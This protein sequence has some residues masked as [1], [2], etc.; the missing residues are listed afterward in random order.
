MLLPAST[1]SQRLAPSYLQALEPIR[2]L[3]HLRTR[4][5]RLMPLSPLFSSA[6][7]KGPFTNL[8]TSHQQVWYCPGS[9]QDNYVK[10]VIVKSGSDLGLQFYQEQNGGPVLVGAVYPK[11]QV[12]LGRALNFRPSFIDMIPRRRPLPQL[13]AL[14][15]T[16]LSRLC[17]LHS[18]AQPTTPSLVTLLVQGI[19]AFTSQRMP[20]TY[21]SLVLPKKLRLI[22]SR[23]LLL[24][25]PV[26][27]GYGEAYD[28]TRGFGCNWG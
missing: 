10:L 17:C 21:D 2:P 1:L 22:F 15:L 26:Y 28:A 20:I 18:F 11:S 27:Q 5:F 7:L 9:S 14:T 8:T 16:Q 6:R 13:T 25:L 24:Y 4:Y 3:I 23:A 12:Y 19:L